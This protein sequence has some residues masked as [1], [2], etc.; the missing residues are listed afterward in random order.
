[1]SSPKI[2]HWGNIYSTTKK[3]VSKRQN[4]FIEQIP[5]ASYKHINSN[6]T[7]MPNISQHITSLNDS[8]VT[9]PTDFNKKMDTAIDT[10]TSN[11]LVT[12]I[13]AIIALALTI[14]VAFGI[15]A[16]FCRK[17]SS[18]CRIMGPGKCLYKRAPILKRP[19]HIFFLFF[20]FIL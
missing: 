16:F 5:T 10:S 9:P 7:K 2:L 13:F 20:I 17:K 14:V 4:N 8:Y 11:Q 15:L 12:I 18:K 19:P 3:P 6:P 1:M